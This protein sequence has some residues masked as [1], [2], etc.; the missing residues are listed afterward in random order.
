MLVGCV[1]RLNLW[2]AERAPRNV[3]P[4]SAGRAKGESLYPLR[5][6]VGG[7][8]G[9][10]GWFDTDNIPFRPRRP[11]NESGWGAKVLWDPGLLI[12]RGD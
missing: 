5:A 6:R 1:T 4:P 10:R 11:R 2:R 12:P 3:P 8:E 9:Y 7:S